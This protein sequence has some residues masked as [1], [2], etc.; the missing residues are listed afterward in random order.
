M[1]SWG[2]VVKMV[3]SSRGACRQN[4]NQRIGQRKGVGVLP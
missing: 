2:I 1:K 3:L 4:R